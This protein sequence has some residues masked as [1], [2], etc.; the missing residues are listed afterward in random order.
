MENIMEVTLCSTCINTL[1]KVIA[2]IISFL[3]SQ[4]NTK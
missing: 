2:L 4:K 1:E 3:S